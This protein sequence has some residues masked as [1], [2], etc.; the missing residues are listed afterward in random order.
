[1][2]SL[3]YV[4]F[5][6][7]LRAGEITAPSS[8]RQGHTSVREMSPW[9]IG[10]SPPR[11]KLLLKR[12]RPTLQKRSGN[13]HGR[14]IEQIV[15]VS[16]YLG[17]CGFSRGPFFTFKEGTPLSRELFVMR[18]RSALTVAAIQVSHFA[19]HSFRIGVAST[20]ATKRNR[21]LSH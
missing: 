19:G 2:G 14:N 16:A 15:S 12:Q 3:Y 11:Y 4:L 9:T 18:V 21:R 5:W 20:A 8:N 7:S 17:V 1:M 13:F 10:N 6:L